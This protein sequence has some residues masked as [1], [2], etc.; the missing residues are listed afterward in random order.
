M[1]LPLLVINSMIYPYPEDQ[2]KDKKIS[3]SLLIGL[4]AF[5]I[6]DMAELSFSDVGCI[7]NYGAGWPVLFYL[8]L[9]M[10]AIMTTFY[11]GLEQ[12]EDEPKNGD[13]V[14]TLMNWVFNDVLFLVVRCKVMY[15]QGHAYFGLIFVIKES[16]SVVVRGLIFGYYLHKKLF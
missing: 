10:S 5:D 8:A 15:V 14:A 16:L 4:S 3:T 12:V 7:Q 9:G 11:W 2:G 1:T 6:I 13:F